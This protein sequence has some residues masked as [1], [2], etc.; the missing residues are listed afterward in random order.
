[1]PLAP[2]PAVV[3]AAE[4]LQHL[5]SQP[6][7]RLSVSDVARAIGMPRATCDTVLRALA[8]QGFVRRDAELRYA[9]GPACIVVGD[10]ARVANAAL[11]AAAPHAEALARSLGAFSAVTIRERDET[12]VTDVFDFGPPLGFRA[13]IGEAIQLVPPFGAS[14]VAWDDDATIATWLGRAEPPLSPDELEQ[15]RTA[16]ET[17]R[18][19]GYSVTLMT[20]RQPTL[21][22]ALERLPEGGA[23]ARR[24][25]DEAVRHIAHSE[26]LPAEIDADATI[27]VAQ[28]SSPVFEADGHVGASIML[29]G[30]AHD[31]TVADIDD[32]GSRVR[33]A[34][35]QATATLRTR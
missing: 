21:I 34:A 5:A 1:M 22:D 33:N 16:L 7:Q 25:R 10:A 28:I 23:D 9:L 30:P 31:V 15:Y 27:R 35:D 11:R 19:R 26:Y 17:V 6:L 3:R 29:L 4:V 13:R 20:A 32:L 14:F 2:S 18:R 12:R 8:E 24:E